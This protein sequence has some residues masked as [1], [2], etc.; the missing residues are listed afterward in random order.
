METTLMHN[1][2]PATRFDAVDPLH[3]A[4][5]QGSGEWLTFR[6]GSEEYGVDILSVQEIRSYERPTRLVHAPAVVKGVVNLRGIMVPIVDMRMHFD[7][8]EVRYDAFTVVIVLNID[9]QVVG[10]VIDG[11]SDVVILGPDQIKPAP[12]LASNGRADAIRGIGHAGDRTLLLL[13]IRE[14]M[15]NPALGLRSTRLQ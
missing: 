7:L 1:T 8:P 10:M 14:L 11:V 15:Q 5:I 2:V 3:A 4:G 6:L 13:D 9:D 12:R